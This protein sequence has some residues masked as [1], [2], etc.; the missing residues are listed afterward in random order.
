M[1]MEE[2]K[3]ARR[4]S[5]RS[6]PTLRYFFLD[7]DLHKVLSVTRAQDLVV[8]WNYPKE[9]RVGYIWSD[10]KRR[11]EKA[12]TMQQVGKMLGRHR[13]TIEKDIIY[14]NIRRPQRSYTLPGKHPKTHYFTEKDILDFHD[15]LLTV[16]VGR[17]RADGKITPKDMVSRNELKAMMKND[18]MT[19]VKND[20]GEFIPVW[21]EQGW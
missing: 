13:V 19:Y 15:Y 10:V 1:A 17:P 20:D 14:G 21:R 6:K 9:R 8:C 2:R 3:P 11:H 12:F 4:S 16:N 18:V 7:G 5:K